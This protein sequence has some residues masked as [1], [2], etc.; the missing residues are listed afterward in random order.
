[1]RKIA[2]IKKTRQKHSRQRR[3]GGIQRGVVW[4]WFQKT[5]A[6]PNV[7]K[8]MDGYH[9]CNYFGWMTCHATQAK[10]HLLG[11]ICKFSSQSTLRC[12]RLHILMTPQ[13]KLF[14]Y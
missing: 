5:R 11:V 3:K 6:S 8:N 2:L 10:Q 13:D 4:Q 14:M 12:E 9:K 7:R 1:M